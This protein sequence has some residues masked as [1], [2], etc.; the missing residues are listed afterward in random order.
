MARA[1]PHNS[2]HKAGAS[3]GQSAVIAGHAEA[4]IHTHSSWN[5]LDTPIDLTFPS[6][7]CGRKLTQKWEDCANPAVTVTLVR[8][9]FFSSISVIITKWCWRKWCY[10]RTCYIVLS[11]IT[12]HFSKRQLQGLLIPGSSHAS[13]SAIFKNVCFSFKWTEIK[14]SWRVTRG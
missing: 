2:G 8:N 7:G 13:L 6:L 9:W 14:R 12:A 5:N 10:W 1:Y 11:E 4:H 3:P